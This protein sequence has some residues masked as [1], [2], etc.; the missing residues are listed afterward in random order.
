MVSKYDIGQK[1][2]ITPV[3]EHLSPRGS[4]LE[5]YA[6]QSGEITDYHWISL[7]RGAKVV[8]IY[9]VRIENSEVEIILHED[10]LQAKLG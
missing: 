9:T 5:L 1:V 6:G 3:R 10:E 8:Y 4:D 2:M 7:D